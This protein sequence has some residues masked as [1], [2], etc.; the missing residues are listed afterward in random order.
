MPYRYRSVFLCMT[1]ALLTL[2]CGCSNRQFISG[3]RTYQSRN[4]INV[5]DVSENE[6]WKIGIAAAS[7]AFDKVS[8]TPG[9]N[10]IHI[11]HYGIIAGQ[12]RATIEPVEMRSKSNKHASGFVYDVYAKGAGLNRTLMP[13]YV[14]KDFAKELESYIAIQKVRRKVL[15]GFE[16][17]MVQGSLSRSSGTCWLVDSRGYLV[18]CE[19]VAGNKKTLEVILPDGT[20]HPAAV[21]ITDKANDL[22]ILKINPLPEKYRPI[23]VALSGI[24]N[25]GEK[26]YVL[27]FP[28][29]ERIG[30]ALKMSDGIISSNLGF[31][32]N[33]TEY[34]VNAS[35]NGGNSGGPVLDAHGKAIGVVSAKLVS[36]ELE[37]I[38]YIKKS[39]A[40]ALLFAQ[41]GISPMPTITEEFSSEEIYS[42]YRNSVFLIK[43]Y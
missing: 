25:T 28:E 42:Q 2:I 30:N 10:Q 41:V 29:G 38:G 26:I 34:Q 5:L 3:T 43:R 36:L 39:T 18:T 11:N 8:A 37:G 1:L 20:T 27:G 4:C 17:S 21:V 32:N 15:C 13:G 31:K 23:P 22:A 14:A 35:I 16:K 19:H 7:N 24:S 40:L 12:A 9:T 6:A 33:I